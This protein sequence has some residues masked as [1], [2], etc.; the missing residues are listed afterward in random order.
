MI[1]TRHPGWFD[2]FFSMRNAR[3][4]ATCLARLE[5]ALARWALVQQLPSAPPQNNQNIR[6]NRRVKS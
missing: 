5:V 4:G 2:N 1:E 3:M 6:D